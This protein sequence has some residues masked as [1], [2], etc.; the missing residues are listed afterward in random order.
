MN[1]FE[2]ILIGLGLAMDCFAV[3]LSC[4]M[5]RCKINKL[6]ALKIAFFFGLFQALMPVIGWLLGLSFKNLISEFDHWMA[7]GILGAIGIKMIIEAF[8]KEEE[9]NIKITRLWV[10]AGLSLATSIDAL[11]VGITFAFLEFN[12]L[13]TVGIIGLVTFIISLTGIYIGKKFNFINAKK[14]EIIG[15]L[16]LIAIGIK[17]LVE[18]LNA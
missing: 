8:K 10:L 17:I 7:F 15:G 14:A 13:L 2:I 1:I 9:K 11:I 4:S 5:G 3:S 18:H 12:I 6:Q 16:V